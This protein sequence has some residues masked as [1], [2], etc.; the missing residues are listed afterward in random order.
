MLLRLAGPAR[1]T[2]VDWDSITFRVAGPYGL[3]VYPKIEFN[4]PLNDTKDEVGPLFAGTRPLSQT[5]VALSQ[6]GSAG[7]D[8]AVT[9]APDASRDADAP[10]GHLPAPRRPDSEDPADRAGVSTQKQGSSTL[11]RKG[12]SNNAVS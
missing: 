8:G 9:A 6:R 11:S 2:R 7:R 4:N 10:C 1:V 12:G 3:P 5:L